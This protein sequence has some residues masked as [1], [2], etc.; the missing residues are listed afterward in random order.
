MKIALFR[1]MRDQYSR[2]SKNQNSVQQVSQ[3]SFFLRGTLQRSAK[4]KTTHLC[5]VAISG[6]KHSSLALAIAFAATTVSL[7]MPNMAMGQAI[8]VNGGSI[9]GVITDASGAAINSA[10]ITVSS[11]QT[12]F[13]KSYKTDAAGLYT[14]G[15]LIPGNYQVTVEASGF[16]KLVADTVVLTGTAT[17]GNYKLSVGSSTEEITVT[18]GA[19]QVN[20][21]QA[22]VQNVITTQQIETLPING[23]NFLDLAQL[24]PGAILQSG[25]T[26]DPTKAGYSA[27]GFSGVSGRTTRILLDGQDI[28]DETVGTTVFNVSQGAIDQFQISRSN[29]DVSGEIGSTGQVLVSTRTGTNAFHGMAFY[30]FQ[31]HTVG[32]AKVVGLDAPFQRNQF[33]GSIGG[34]VLKDKLFFFANA[35]RIKQ[36]ES[37]PAQIG[38]L[39]AQSPTFG[40]ILS[41]YPSVP[42]PYRSTYST[43]RLDYSG[44]WGVHY[45]A[46]INYDVNSAVTNGGD[47]YSNYANRDNTWGLAGGADFVR[48]NFTHSFRGSYE[49]FHNLIVDATG[50]GVYVAIPGLLIRDVSQGLY[51]GPNDNAPQDTYQSDKQLRYDG[52]WTKSAHNIRYGVSLN[53]IEQ[54]G[55]AS[56]F[57]LAPRVSLSPSALINPNGDPG[58][59][60]NN[61]NASVGIRFG[62]GLGYFTDQSAFGQPGGGSSDWRTGAY[63][64]DSWKI[65]PQFTVNYGIRWLRDTGRTDNWIDPIPCSSI[66]TSNFP[67]PPCSGN[68]L[69]LDQFGAGLGDRIRQPNFDF[70]P[71]IGFTYSLDSAGK[72]VIRSAVGIFRENIVFNAV[73]FDTPFKL[74]S[75]LFNDYSHIL[76]AGTYVFKFPDGSTTSTIN[77]EPISDI[78]QEPLSQ[79]GPKFVAL[80]AQYQRISKAGGAA[81]NG[82]FIGNTLAIPSG[83]AAY[84]PNFKT[85]YS[86]H[87]NFGVQRELWSGAVLA[88]DYVHQATLHIAQT[89][90]ANHIGDAKYL[91]TAAAQYAIANTLAAC[92]VASIDQAISSCPGLYDQSQGPVGATILD[93]ANN[94]LDSG[95]VYLGGA[96]AAQYGLT[97]GQGAAFPGANPYMGNGFFNFPAGR[98]GY[99]ALQVNL[100]QQARHP[101]KG[102]SDS[103]FEFSYA[104]SKFVT[105][106]TG[107]S[108]E[109]FSG[110]AYDYNHPTQYIGF[111]GSD[112]RHNISFGGAATVVHGPQIA[113][114]GHFRSATPS[115]LTLDNTAG[116]TAQIF[117]TDVTGD[118]TIGDLAP[119]TNPG[120]FM[121][122]IHGGDLKKF[123]NNYNNTS[124]GRLTPAGTALVNSGLFTSGEL[125]HLGGVQQPIYD[126]FSSVFQNPMF[127]AIDASLSY[128]IH[129]KFIS[130]AAT[131]VPKISM[132]NVANFA[133]WGGTTTT[134]INQSDAGSG[135]G[136]SGYVNGDNGFA[137]KNQT[138]VGRGSGTFDQG[139]PRSTE[140]QLTFNF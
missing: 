106:S 125:S 51:T 30:D 58:D 91:N 54:G 123:I 111:G 47:A 64:S 4:S 27:I 56:F 134:L 93:F 20:T 25:Q 8:S 130:E 33:G 60:L 140:F 61:Y 34:P 135:A 42:A 72:T 19:I 21:E 2:N 101:M 59:L 71:Q 120:A 109:F 15:P 119:G 96:P 48:G 3:S 129:L 87:F 5:K 39:F 108:D 67:N 18:A 70:A 128:P 136:A 16:Q 52:S 104:Y 83:N 82:S 131:L 26:F 122:S 77:G 46:R 90:D 127:K 116:S 74:Q 53:R 88:V 22:G 37:S 31:D 103:N 62:N 44:P 85:P 57:G 132:Y 6:L 78:C 98:S 63:V 84:S 99:D 139:G 137:F 23:R 14:I 13:S 102:L 43:G 45:F 76:C 10:I 114:I 12:G 17:N 35:E 121:R 55:F 7:V 92:G 81:Q 94:G 89:I 9:Q 40:P 66:N 124:A 79:S 24:E 32:F 107:G 65:K 133:N 95:N 50:S 105:S 97:P 29:N 69:L 75:G 41:Q 73:Q 126:G 80:Q 115:N 38:S 28:T 138:R 11:K 110:S 112:N 118:G 1:G 86:I 100:R 68:Q 117:M 113:V 36:D 49:K